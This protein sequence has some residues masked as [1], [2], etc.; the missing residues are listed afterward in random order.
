MDDR[1]ELLSEFKTRYVWWT[2]EPTD[3]RVIA[4]VMDVGGYE[5]IRRLEAVFGIGELSALMMRAQPGWISERSWDFWRG[6][7]RVPGLPAAPPRRSFHDAA[8]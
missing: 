2:D 4:Q 5:D 1:S 3:D 6:R 7:L 8:V